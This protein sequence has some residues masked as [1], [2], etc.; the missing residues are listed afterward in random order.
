VIYQVHQLFTPAVVVVQDTP[1]DH[2]LEVL[3]EVE[4]HSVLVQVLVQLLETELQ[5]EAEEEAVHTMAQMALL[6]L[7]MLTLEVQV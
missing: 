5:T 7:M 4:R 2:Y 6:D 1:E 3:E